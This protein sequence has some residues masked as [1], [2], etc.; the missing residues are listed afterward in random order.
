MAQL[1]AKYRTKINWVNNKD[2][3]YGGNWSFDPGVAYHNASTSFDILSKEILRIGTKYRIEFELVEPKSGTFVDGVYIVCDNYISSS[4]TGL[5]KKNVTFTANASK[6][7]I[8]PINSYSNFGITNFSIQEV[9]YEELDVFDIQILYNKSIADV[10]N[11]DERGGA[12]TQE[13]YLPGTPK[14]NQ[15]F[16]NIFEI[17]EENNFNIHAKCPA[18]IAKDNSII[19]EGY[20]Q[21]MSISNLNGEIQYEVMFYSN[22]V[23]LFSDIGDTYLKDLDLSEF[24]HTAILGNVLNSWDNSNPLPYYYG[25]INYGGER[26]LDLWGGIIG[27]GRDTTGVGLTVADIF[28][29]M[30]VKPLVDHIFS[31]NNYSYTSTIFSSD[32][33]NK[34]VLPFV[35]NEEVLGGYHKI[36]ENFAGNSSVTWE[37]VYTVQLVPFALYQN[38]SHH[39]N[40]TTGQFFTDIPIYIQNKGGIFNNKFKTSDYY[41]HFNE[42]NSF[43]NDYT[44]TG[45]GAFTPP[46]ISPNTPQSNICLHGCYRAFRDGKYK[47][48]ANCKITNYSAFGGAGNFLYKI[49]A[50]KI[51]AANVT[52]TESSSSDY[53]VVNSPEEIVYIGEYQFNSGSQN[54]EAEFDCEAGDMIGFK[55]VVKSDQINQTGNYND[56]FTTMSIYNFSVFEYK[57]GIGSTIQAKN[58][59]P[60]NLKVKEFLKSLFLMYN[61]YIEQDKA[62]PRNYIIETRDVFYTGGTSYDWSQ[63]IDLDSIIIETPKEYQSKFLKLKYTDGGDYWNEYFNKQKDVDKVGYGGKL[64]EFQTEFLT[65][66]ESIEPSFA[67]T[68]LRTYSDFTVTNYMYTTY[69]EITDIKED[70]VTA[71][72]RKT[73]WEPRILISN[74]LSSNTY[75]TAVTYNFRFQSLD[76]GIWPYMGHIYDPH[77]MTST[78]NW[79]INFET[80]IKTKGV[81]QLMF[82]P[83]PS[84]TM[85]NRNLYNLYWKNYLDKLNNKDARII[86]ANFY[87]TADDIKNLS[88]RDKVLI[89][90][91]YYYPNVITDF[92]VDGG[93]LTEVELLKCIDEL[94]SDLSAYT[95]STNVIAPPTTGGIGQIN[96]GNGNV[97]PSGGNSIV[98]GNNII[99]G[100]STMIVGNNNVGTQSGTV[101]IGGTG[102]TANQ[103]ATIIGANNITVQ[104]GGTNAVVI[105]ASNRIISDDSLYLG[106]LKITSAGDIINNG[107]ELYDPGADCVQV[108]FSEAELNDSGENV[109][110]AANWT[111]ANVL[112][113]PSA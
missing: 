88:F 97:Q 94:P 29:S 49:F 106:N 16:K 95:T 101:I 28:P 9:A 99:A 70:T 2:W 90:N 8:V 18:A 92:D 74:A 23:D 35:D 24:D 59:V 46:T 30:R 10:K 44:I 76:L 47:I 27:S 78:T 80:P 72:D 3:T 63:K 43:Y 57:Y 100:Q 12:Y 4:L 104:S 62:D 79:D 105:G 42:K 1:L 96:M 71:L 98:I 81:S 69:S 6:I 65:E 5:G 84:N 11:I 31:A 108:K 56:F 17:T 61:L 112:I 93:S 53:F 103:T 32:N 50:F 22:V 107:S 26:Y 14:N 73:E 45:A 20:I 75:N 83:T 37:N 55:Y 67:P 21:L 38:K 91:V 89:D 52:F 33:F 15:F 113:D 111:D 25:Y 60:Q 7:Q 58:I 85:T 51:N 48:T 40:Y 77:D 34:L 86:T 109:M 87:L 110:W 68:V 13:M 39:S 102:V 66:E 64:Y 41:S 54:I 82:R 19:E 36:A